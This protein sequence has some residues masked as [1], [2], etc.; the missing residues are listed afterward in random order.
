VFSSLV[1]GAFLLVVLTLL[2]QRDQLLAE[3]QKNAAIS[4]LGVSSQQI[5]GFLWVF[6]A[7]SIFWALS[8]MALAVLAFRRVGSARIALVVSAGL[9]GA[10]S[11][12][13][14]P[15]GWLHAVAA[16]TAGA[17]LLRRSSSQWYAGHD[18]PISGPR[19]PQQPMQGPPTQP[20]SS[21]KPPVW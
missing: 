8:A 9:A 17:L 18:Q 21:G 14:V 4:D 5:L 7:V 20:P 2:V 6:S 1:A 19:P 12:F 3:M 13:V 11:L 15:F 16:F 10:V